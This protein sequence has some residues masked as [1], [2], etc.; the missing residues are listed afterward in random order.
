MGIIEN[1]RGIRSYDSNWGLLSL[2]NYKSLGFW[3]IVRD[4]SG[5]SARNESRN[6]LAHGHIYLL[7]TSNSFND[8]FERFNSDAISIRLKWLEICLHLEVIH[9]IDTT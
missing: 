4:G 1:A 8:L 6:V 2:L 3:S 5:M 9:C 7:S